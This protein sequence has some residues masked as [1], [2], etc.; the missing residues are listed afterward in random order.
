MRKVLFRAISETAASTQARLDNPMSIAVDSSGNL[1]IAN[2]SANRV[3]KVTPS[4][5]IATV[6]GNG[7]AAYGGDNGP[8]P[9]AALNYPDAV[10]VD[11]AGNVYI[12]DA[13]NPEDSPR[14][15]VLRMIF[16]TFAGN[17]SCCY[18]RCGYR[19]RWWSGHGRHP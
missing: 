12:A 14:E 9:E 5:T 3:R 13:R 16:T 2:P 15:Y 8:G 6:A 19:R 7:E 18:R 11:S 4:G 1:Y 17:G 10:A